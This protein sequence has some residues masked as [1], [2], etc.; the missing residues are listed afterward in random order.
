MKAR[1]MTL[2]DWLRGGAWPSP[3]RAVRCLLKCSNER[4]PH[5]LLPLTREILSSTLGR[6]PLRKRRRVGATAGQYAPNFPGHTRAAMTGTK[7]SYPERG[8]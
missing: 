3:V 8:R 6:P 4:D 2:P 7:G 5:A 1:L